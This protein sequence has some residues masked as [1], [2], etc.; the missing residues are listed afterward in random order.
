MCSFSCPLRQ[1]RAIYK[2]KVS[3][4]EPW[5]FFSARVLEEVIERMWPVVDPKAGPGQSEGPHSASFLGMQAPPAL[6]VTSRKRAWEQCV[7]ETIWMD[8]VWL[9][10]M[11]PLYKLLR[12]WWTGAGIYLSCRCP[13]K[14]SLIKT[15]PYQSQAVCLFL[16]LTQSCVYRGHFYQGNPWGFEPVP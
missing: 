10:P 8:C 9:H 16:G 7:V 2:D 1:W 6:G 5:P 13:R 15:A 4:S 11:M 3:V 12:V 14:T